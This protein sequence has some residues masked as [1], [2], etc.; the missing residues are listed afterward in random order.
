M[1]K[2][3]VVGGIPNVYFHDCSI[4]NI[5][6]RPVKTAS[7]LSIKEPGDLIVANLMGPYELSFNHKKYILMIQDAFS[8]V[9]VAIPLSNKSESKTYLINWMKKFTNV[10]PYKIK[11]IRTDNGTEFKNSILNEFLT[12]HGIIN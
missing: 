6:H 9:V 1:Q 7:C 4:A 11:T 3:S 12:Q 10:T 5:Q 2:S 8:R